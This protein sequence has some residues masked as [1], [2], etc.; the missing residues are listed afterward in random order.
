MTTK[1]TRTGRPTKP[2]SPG[3]RVSLGLKVTP[4]I[5][6][7]LDAAA[8]KS[9]RTQSQE[10]ERRLTQSFEQASIVEQ[11]LT[12]AYG[13]RTTALILTLAY[14]MHETGTHAGFIATR[15]PEGARDWLANPSAFDQVEKTVQTVMEGF[16]PDGE[17]VPL[18]TGDDELN[19]RYSRLG[20]LI[21]AG[22]LEALKNPQRGGGIGDW[23]RPI[24]ELLGDAATRIHVDDSVVILSA[25]SPKAGQPVAALALLTKAKGKEGKDQ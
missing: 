25:F 24:R 10:A 6:G 7:L 19:A 18:T 5:K 2:A 22:A 23:A 9:G 3:K 13:P 4:E 15:T 8:H 16:R 11:A 14:V 12:L 21:A 17:I 1:G 20:K